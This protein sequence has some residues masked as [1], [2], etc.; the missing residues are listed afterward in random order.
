VSQPGV[1]SGIRLLDGRRGLVLSGLTDLRVQLG[2][3]LYGSLSRPGRA[4]RGP[5]P[6]A[7]GK[8]SAEAE[9]WVR[10]FGVARKKLE[11]HV[12]GFVR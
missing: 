12:A 3:E 1:C 5:R 8:L 9:A 7:Y 2:Y 4:A 10:Q 11:D 6:C